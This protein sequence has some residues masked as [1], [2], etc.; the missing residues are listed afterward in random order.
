VNGRHGRVGFL[1]RL[2]FIFSNA[3]PS[4]RP[5][6]VARWPLI[7]RHPVH[8]CCLNRSGPSGVEKPDDRRNCLAL[9]SATL[10]VVV[11]RLGQNAVAPPDAWIGDSLILVGALDQRRSMV[12]WSNPRPAT[13]LA[14]CGGGD[15]CRAGINSTIFLFALATM[16]RPS[17]RIFRRS[18]GRR[19]PYLGIG[20]AVISYTLWLCASAIQSPTLVA[21]RLANEPADG[22][23]SGAGPL[24]GDG[25]HG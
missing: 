9:L 11:P 2:Q 6:A 3:L 22:P 24:L 1:W 17:R 14:A 16:R 4:P 5:F 19:W 18:F 8:D 15:R 20:A 23:C 13:A 12:V 25:G 10:G 21:V 7:R